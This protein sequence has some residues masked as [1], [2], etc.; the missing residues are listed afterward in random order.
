MKSPTLIAVPDGVETVKCPEVAV[1]GTLVCNCELEAATAV[2]TVVLRMTPLFA[3]VGSKPLPLIVTEVPAAPIVGENP[4]MA[5]AATMNALAE[6]T[7]PASE[8]TE[9]APV[10]AP[11]GTVA[12]RCPALAEV[13]V[14]VTPLNFTVFA[15]SE[16]LKPLPVIVT[17]VP[18]GPLAGANDS[19]V[20]GAT[21]PVRVIDVTLP[22]ASY[23]Y[24]IDEPSASTT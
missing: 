5:T 9:I 10:V 3:A 17:A 20:S 11:T 16:L 21:P 7:V 22:L 13:T 12:T 15:F 24:C 19:M 1:A 6:V 23:E 4:V 18:T 14:A 2:A 8:A